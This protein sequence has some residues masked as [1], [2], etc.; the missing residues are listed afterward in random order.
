MARQVYRVSGTATIIPSLPITMTIQGTRGA[1]QGGSSYVWNNVNFWWNVYTANAAAQNNLLGDANSPSGTQS[2]TRT[3]GNTIYQSGTARTIIQDW[4]Y[5]LTL[6]PVVTNG[7]GTGGSVSGG[8]ELFAGQAATVTATAN[9]GY[10]FVKWSTDAQGNSTYSANASVSV[11]LNGDMTLYA[12]FAQQLSVTVAPNA[13]DMGEVSFDGTAWSSGATVKTID[14]GTQNVPLY[15]RAKGGYVFYAWLVNGVYLSGSP[16]VFVNPSDGYNSFVAEFR[17]YALSVESSPPG[18][19]EPYIDTPGSTSAQLTQKDYHLHAGITPG[20]D[21]A[22]AVERWEKGTEQVAG[23]AGDFIWNPGATPGADVVIRCVL[24]QTRWMLSAAVQTD[25]GVCYIGEPSVVTAWAERDT[26]VGVTAVPDGH[27]RLKQFITSGGASVSTLSVDPVTGVATANVRHNGQ[28]GTVTAVFEMKDWQLSARMNPADGAGTIHIG[29]PGMNDL[30]YPLDTVVSANV[31]C[32][33]TAPKKVRDWT[34]PWGTRPGSSGASATLNVGA[35]SASV[36]VTANIIDRAYDLTVGKGAHPDYGTLAV[37][38]NGQV[39]VTDEF[40]KSVDGGH[41]VKITAAAK[42]GRKFQGWGYPQDIAETPDGAVF[43]FVMPDAAVYVT[44]NFIPKADVAL[45]AEAVNASDPGRVVGTVTLR[46]QDGTP[47]GATT[48]AEPSRVFGVFAEEGYVLTATDDDED[49]TFLEWRDGDGNPVGGGGDPL[50]LAFTP[51]SG[52][53]LAYRAVYTLRRS[54]PIEV[55]YRTI[56]GDFDDPQTRDGCALAVTTPPSGE[57]GGVPV[58]LVGYN[59]AVAF[60][61]NGAVVT[62]VGGGDQ[63]RWGVAAVNVIDTDNHSIPI[64]FEKAPASVTGSFLMRDRLTVEL[65][66][67]R[68]D[69]PNWRGVTLDYMPCCGRGQGSFSVYPVDEGNGAFF[70]DAAT[71]RMTVMEA[72]GHPCTISACPAPGYAFEG[73]YEKA[74]EEYVKVSGTPIFTF[75]VPDVAS[76]FLVRFEESGKSVRQWNAGGEVLVFEWRSKVFVASVPFNPSCARVYADSYPLLMRVFMASSPDDVM[77]DGMMREAQVR[78]QDPF[79][80]PM[81][82]PE[83]YMAIEIVGNARV[84]FVAVGTSMEGLRNGR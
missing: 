33:P 1:W 67:V 25:G 42:Y 47:E 29:S 63:F 34:T 41:P 68:V 27:F 21:E 69:T 17:E 73:W 30:W 59:R 61:A 36:T 82:R 38:I 43:E 71:G 35:Q 10:R 50:R 22:P 70:E 40:T 57:D 72:K 46:R 9:S 2:V 58:W 49:Y 48:L 84:S 45:T 31:T 23:A 65:V 62:P 66:L 76:V 56:G 75:T 12:I 16:T 14:A 6:A 32:V 78:S 51:A 52:G 15:A 4:L 55:A 74:G 60:S 83:K 64:N 24:A 81:R 20:L 77:G 79:R 37:L 44:A 26:D 7:A 39:Q 80:L 28:D 5:T 11:T 18:W 53:A 13:A 8:G 54:E 19:A 3:L